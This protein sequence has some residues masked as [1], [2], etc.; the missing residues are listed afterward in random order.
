MLAEP[1]QIV[2]VFNT[3]GTPLINVDGSWRRDVIL[4]EQ[5]VI[6]DYINGA[7]SS[8]TAFS[9]GVADRL[10]RADLILIAGIAPMVPTPWDTLLIL[11]NFIEASTN[12]IDGGIGNDLLF[13]GSAADLIFGND[14]NDH[15]FGGLGNDVLNGGEIGRASCR[16]RV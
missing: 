11:I 1:G 6:V 4:E 14:G 2:P 15:I 3:D 8:G 13:G 5:G 16:E 10:L 12:E 9:A 7:I